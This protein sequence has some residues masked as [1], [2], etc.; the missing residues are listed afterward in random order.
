MLEKIKSKTFIERLIESSNYLIRENEI[1]K[2]N[3][4]RDLEAEKM[5]NDFIN[6][7]MYPITETTSMENL[8]F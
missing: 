1:E 3:L 7:Y 5:V 8:E 6:Q 2:E 4:K